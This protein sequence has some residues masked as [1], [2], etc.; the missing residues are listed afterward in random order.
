MKEIYK[1]YNKNSC[2]DNREK[3]KNEK[4]VATDLS[5]HLIYIRGK[6]LELKEK[7]F[8][9]KADLWLDYVIMI[10]VELI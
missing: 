1:L 5:I 3:R 7:T 6:E 9:I 8:S 2:K 4:I 10:N